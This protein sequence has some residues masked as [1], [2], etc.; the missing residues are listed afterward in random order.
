MGLASKQ[1]HTIT[2][3]VSSTEDNPASNGNQVPDGK[4]AIQTQILSNLK[5]KQ[6]IQTPISTTPQEAGDQTPILS[7]PSRRSRRSKRQS[8][9][10]PSRRNGRSNANPQQPPQGETGDPNA[11]PQQPP[12][13][14]TGDRM[15]ILSKP[16]TTNSMGTK[17]I[18][19]ERVM[20]Q[21]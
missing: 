18:Q 14:E 19:M 21:V 5:E 11:N 10:T 7:N 16:L 12:Q 17:A 4:Q 6:A 20:A 13:G 1:R 15:A 9:A 3:N 2:L 8:S